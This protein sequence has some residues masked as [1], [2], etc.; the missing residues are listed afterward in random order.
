MT[1]WYKPVEAL[2]VKTYSHDSRS[3]RQWCSKWKKLKLTCW[4]YKLSPGDITQSSFTNL[5]KLSFQDL[6]Y[7]WAHVVSPISILWGVTGRYSRTV[8]RS[9]CLFLTSFIH[10]LAPLN[11]TVFTLRVLLL[12][13]NITSLLLQMTSMPLPFWFCHYTSFIWY[14]CHI[15]PGLSPFPK[16]SDFPLTSDPVSQAVR[17]C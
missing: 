3:A 8:K 1:E 12:L 7:G 11:S 15:K 16:W 6:S 2:G 9:N 5:K 4:C 14:I 10:E 17:W 13:C